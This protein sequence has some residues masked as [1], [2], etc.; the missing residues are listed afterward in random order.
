MQRFYWEENKW[1][2]EVCKFDS[3]QKNYRIKINH[4]N[5]DRLNKRIIIKQYII[6][7]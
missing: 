4:I 6:S 1:A 7:I 3:F 2:R 5:V